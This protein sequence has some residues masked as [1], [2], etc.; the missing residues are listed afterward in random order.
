MAATIDDPLRAQPAADTPPSG[1]ARSASTWASSVAAMTRSAPSNRVQCC[2]LLEYQRATQPLA[3][4]AANRP[5]VPPEIEVMVDPPAAS[6]PG[7][8]CRYGRRARRRTTPSPGCPPHGRRTR[9]SPS[10]RAS[11]W[12]RCL[13]VH[14]RTGQRRGAPGATIDQLPDGGGAAASGAE[15]GARHHPGTGAGRRH[16]GRQRAGGATS[17]RQR[18]AGRARARRRDP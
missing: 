4:P 8:A 18:R 9:R 6:P 2:P 12:P 17:D 10:R 11:S 7:A 3:L 15:A 14:L 1:P 13:A 16:D 5:S